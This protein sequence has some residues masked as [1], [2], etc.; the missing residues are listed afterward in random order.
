MSGYEPWRQS[1]TWKAL[2][3]AALMSV[4]SSGGV[5]EKPTAA[6]KAEIRADRKRQRRAR[7]AGRKAS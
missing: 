3:A 4:A 7:K 2:E 1:A 5:R 6:E